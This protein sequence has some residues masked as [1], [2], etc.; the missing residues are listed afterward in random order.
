M[1]QTMSDKSDKTAF[2]RGYLCGLIHGMGDTEK[3]KA[4]M[5]A[6][7]KECPSIDPDYWHYRFEQ[8]AKVGS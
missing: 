4:L 2:E 6:T 3:V 1:G 7:L 8:A 5:E